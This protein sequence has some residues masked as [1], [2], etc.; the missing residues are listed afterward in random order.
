MPP[1][2]EQVQPGRGDDDVGL[3]FRAATRAAPAFGVKRVDAIGDDG[4]VAPRMMA[5]N[6]SPSGTKHIR[7]SHGW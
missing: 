1:S 7:W 4:G 3:E 2:G 5:A 6:R